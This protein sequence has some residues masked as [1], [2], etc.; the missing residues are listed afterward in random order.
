MPDRTKLTEDQLNHRLWPS[1]DAELMSP[2][3]RDLFLRRQENIKAYLDAKDLAKG[4]EPLPRQEVHRLLERCLTLHPDKRIWGWR[5]IVPEARVKEY[6]RTAH[7]SPMGIGKRGGRAG[8]ATQL[9]KS[10]PEL[11]EEAKNNFLGK[12]NKDPKLNVIETCTDIH[13]KFLKI[14]KVKLIQQLLSRGLSQE[15]AEEDY[16]KLYPFNTADRMETTFRK[17]LKE[18][19]D[20]HTRAAIKARHGKDAANRY[21]ADQA[22][23]G[24][25]RITEPYQYAAL[26]VHVLNANFWIDPVKDLFMPARSYFLV[27]PR[28]MTLVECLTGA[29][30]AYLLVIKREPDR[31]DV[32][33]LI[34]KAIRPWVPM[35]LN[36]DG[37]RYI[38]GAGMPSAV[39]KECRYAIWKVLLIDNALAF[40]ANDVR[41]GVKAVTGGTVN[42]GPGRWPYKRWPVE[43]LFNLLEEHGYHK[44]INTLGSEPRDPRRLHS[45]EAAI[46]YKI[47]LEDLF[48]F[49]EA[50]LA[51]HNADTYRKVGGL[52]KLDKLRLYAQ[53]HHIPILDDHSRLVELN[54][55]I[56]CTVRGNKQKGRA[57]Y[58]QTKYA[59][60][61]GECLTY[62]MVK[63]KVFIRLDPDRPM[64]CP[65]FRLDTKH[66]IGDV[67]CK[68][69]TLQKPHTIEQRIAYNNKGLIDIKDDVVKDYVSKL[70]NRG[71]GRPKQESQPR[72]ASPELSSDLLK[73]L[74]DLPTFEV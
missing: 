7:V 53:G 36:I 31:W 14:L 59:R 49:T 37:L 24:P 11:F 4:T 17:R 13:Q 44:I 48:Q 25:V 20:T 54:P 60:Y 65:V 10:Y 41:N 67:F 50:L 69:K 70:S 74:S 21:V 38:E 46:T 72:P 58:I 35:E 12:L 45:E 8:A 1:V 9:L 5:A 18:L 73:D 57:P 15:Q 52:S 23:E 43:S 34:K 3:S 47:G 26:D 68:S 55:R 42:D 22:I 62:S 61:G 30:L 51:N 66:K 19:Y 56:E 29:I 63:K 28:L 32:L 27:R 64:K 6:E 40:L 16:L 71:K 39:I 2:D 33:R